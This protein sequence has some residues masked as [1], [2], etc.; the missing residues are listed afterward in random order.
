ML[1]KD[2]MR[3]RVITVTPKMT[4]REVAKL[5]GDRHISGAPVVGPEGQIIGVISQTDLVRQIRESSAYEISNYHRELEGCVRS[6]GFHYE[7]PDYSR[8]EQV[9]TPWVISFEADTPV[10]ELARQMLGKHIHRIIITKDGQLCGIVT[11]VDML[12][13]L[14]AMHEKLKATTAY[15]AKE[16]WMAWASI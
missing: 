10:V 5:F 3:K 13:A 1:A 14:L 8:V 15:P 7:D 4:L 6:N 12:R 16:T 9:M 2:I 11:S